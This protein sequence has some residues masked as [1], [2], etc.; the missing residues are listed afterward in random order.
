MIV[1]VRL[2]PRSPDPYIHLRQVGILLLIEFYSI[3]H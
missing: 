3:V 1:L 2:N